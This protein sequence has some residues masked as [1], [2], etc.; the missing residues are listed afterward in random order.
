MANLIFTPVQLHHE[1][2]KA[3]I[4]NSNN[5]CKVESLF[6]YS[7]T[8]MLKV[9]SAE[10]LGSMKRGQGFRKATLKSSIQHIRYQRPT[11]SAAT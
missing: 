4:I 1:I 11:A 6:I 5:I 8:V 7:S 9:G 3:L 10:S 2:R